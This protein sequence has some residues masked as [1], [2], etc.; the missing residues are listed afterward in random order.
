MWRRLI[1]DQETSEVS[2][3]SKLFIKICRYGKQIISKWIF[4]IHKWEPSDEF[5]ELL[6][7]VGCGGGPCTS[8]ILKPIK[9]IANLDIL[10]LAEYIRYTFSDISSEEI[11]EFMLCELHSIAKEKSLESYI[12]LLI[13]CKMMDIDCVDLLNEDGKIVFTVDF[14]S[15]MRESIRR[16]IV[17]IAI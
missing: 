5:Y 17:D 12:K 4:E 6:S 10:I 3:Y 9:E 13:N 2:D 15:Y 8:Y 7:Y 14:F 1:A 11:R 16:V